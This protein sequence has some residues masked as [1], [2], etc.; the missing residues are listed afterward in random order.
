MVLVY[1]VAF[2]KDYLD[3]FDLMYQGLI[4]MGVDVCLITDQNVKRQGVEVITIGTPLEKM[5]MFAF[6]IYG[7]KIIDFTKYDQVWYSDTDIIFKDNIFDKYKG[8]YVCREP[9]NTMAE[10]HF[11]GLLNDQEVLSAKKLPAINSGLVC[12][13]GDS[14]FWS[15]YQ[16]VTERAYRRRA[17]ISEQH[18]LNWMYLKRRDKYN[19]KLFADEDIGYPAR[20]IKGGYVDHYNCYKDKLT[21]MRSNL[22]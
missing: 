13:P 21:W 10:E 5:Q 4:R 2:G 22:A 8:H 6:R 7:H 12:A 16:T 11:N 9:W 3:Q 17:W 1:L 18:A 19:F 14:L 15:E 20:G